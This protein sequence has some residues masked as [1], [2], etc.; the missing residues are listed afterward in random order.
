M[1]LRGL[2]GVF[3]L[4]GGKLLYNVVLVSAVQHKSVIIIY[5]GTSGKEPAYQCRRHNMQIGSLGGE[6]PLEEGVATHTSILAWRIPWTEEPGGLQSMG[7]Q[8]VGHD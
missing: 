5:G 3:F 6:D 4:I 2:E 1:L 8:R 7:L